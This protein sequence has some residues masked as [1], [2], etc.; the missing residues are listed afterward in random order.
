M[1][2]DKVKKFLQDLNNPEQYGW[3][4]SP[5]VRKVALNLLAELDKGSNTT[6]STIN[7]LNYHMETMH[8]DK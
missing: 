6:Y 8:H 4:V 5:E 7:V 1:N 3:A 2:M